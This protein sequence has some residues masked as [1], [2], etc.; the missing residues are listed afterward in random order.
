M[1]QQ[2]ETLGQ[3]KGLI[4]DNLSVEIEGLSK[5]KEKALGDSIKESLSKTLEG[6]RDPLKAL[7]DGLTTKVGAL[8]DKAFKLPE[9]VGKGI[10]TEIA[11]DLKRGLDETFALLDQFDAAAQERFDQQLEQLAERRSTIEEEISAIEERSSMV[12]ETISALREQVTEAEGAQRDAIVT[13]LADQIN[14]QAEFNGQLTVRR[15]EAKRLEAEEKKIET[16]KA[17]RDKAAEKRQKALTIVNQLATVA[18]LAQ[19]AVTAFAP[20]PAAAA[21]PFGVGLALRIA[22]AVA[23]V[24]SMVST[25]AGLANA[26]KAAE[27]AVLPEFGR[28]GT[29]R[30][31][32]HAQG[33]ILMVSKGGRPMVE[34]EGGEMVL[35]KGVSRNP[36]L[37]GMASLVN[38]MG[39]G[40]NLAE[41]GAVLSTR[42][43]TQYPRFASGG[44]VPTPDIA[45][46]AA[47]A[48][49]VASNTP[50]ADD[51]RALSSAIADNPPVL[52]I[53]DFDVAKDRSNA[54]AAAATISD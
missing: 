20:D 5:E 43:V 10:A 47:S 45:S 1:Q 7:E 6:L 54:R 39:G 33:G 15:E 29:L 17:E 30:G 26:I 8:F 50:T 12:S 13:Q 23:F 19:A 11:T 52:S 18:G 37:R 2:N 38:Q 14:K 40:I 21:L 41:G 53:V 51:F 31:P 42:N 9:G 4:E 48:S 46:V 22:N 49:G 16:Q 28:G 25:V 32:S 35:T 44:T 3:Q 34:A 36:V 24:V 27:G